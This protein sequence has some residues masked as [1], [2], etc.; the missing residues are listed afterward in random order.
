[1]FLSDSDRD[2]RLPLKVQ[3]WSQDSSGVEAWNLAFLL[4]CQSGGRP[5][6]MFRRGIRAFSRRSAG[7]SGLPSC[8]EGILGVTL[9]LVQRNNNLSRVEGELSVLSNCSHIHGVPLEIQ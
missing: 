2:L 3:L 9:E 4:S 1:M 7:V 8:C 5:P 6:V